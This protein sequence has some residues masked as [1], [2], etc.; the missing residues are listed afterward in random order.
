MFQWT[1]TFWQRWREAKNPYRQYKSERDRSLA[2]QALQLRDGDR[3]LEVGCGYGWISKALLAAARIRWVGLDASESMIRQLRGSL[4]G[5]QPN[6]FIGTAYHLPFPAG[7]FDKVLCTGVLMHL[8]DEFGALKEMARV[9]LP[10]GV[11]VCSMNNVLSPFSVPVRLKNLRKNGFVQNFRRP[12]TYSRYLQDL[13]LN[14]RHVA[15]DG[16]FATV[17]VSIGRFCVPPARAFPAL[18]SLDQWAVRRFPR[19]AYE[20]WFVATKDT[21]SCGS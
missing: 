6:A 14:L 21:S 1:P 11:L 19:L 12:G 13:G 16:L 4:A 2:L 20:V 8:A 3:V 5:Y 9:L 18:H 17:G 7:S 15:G 10:G